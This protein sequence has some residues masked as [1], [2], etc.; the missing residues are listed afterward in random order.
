MSR[1]VYRRFWR[2]E[3]IARAFVHAAPGADV[4]RLRETIARTLGRKYDLRIYSSGELMEHL[5]G[6]VR[7]AFGVADVLRD[8]VLLLV[9][10]GMADALGAGIAERTRELRAIRALGVRPRLVRRMVLIEA[11][12]MAALGLVLATA[13]GL[14]G[15]FWVKATFPNLLAW[16]FAFHLP[17]RGTAAVA[18]LVVGVALAAAF[19]PARRAAAL[20]P[21][22]ALR[23]E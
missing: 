16:V 4:A 20:R 18:A 1:D 5:A 7:R 2:N 8:V 6:E 14:L 23:Y 22:A 9:L 13:A 3:R 12:V 21:A 11:L 19:L 15:A 10:I 17:L